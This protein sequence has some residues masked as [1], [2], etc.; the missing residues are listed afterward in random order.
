MDLT[1]EIEETKEGLNAFEQFFFSWYFIIVVSV[2]YLA[3]RTHYHYRLLHPKR[4][5]HD[6]YDEDDYITLRPGD[7]E[8][9]EVSYKDLKKT[10]N[11][12]KL[13]NY[14]ALDGY[15]YDVGLT[16]TEKD[17][18]I[19]QYTGKDITLAVIKGFNEE[20]LSKLFY[21]F[22]EVSEEDRK[23]ID[24]WRK[25]FDMQYP[26]VGRITEFYTQQKPKSRT[27]KKKD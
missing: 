26:R 11:K 23:K 21:Q 4:R 5:A 8:L 10:D 20:N 7:K 12:G 27:S 9:R 13:K 17:E 24:G 15:L 3:Q 18:K 16:F 19:L 22:M 2:I 6:L 25:G 14:V 1:E